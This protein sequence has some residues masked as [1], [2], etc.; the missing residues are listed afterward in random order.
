M[1][2][3][4]RTINNNVLF[5]GTIN[6]IFAYSDLPYGLVFLNGNTRYAL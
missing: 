6:D 4:N 5:N 2:L 1:S 3:L